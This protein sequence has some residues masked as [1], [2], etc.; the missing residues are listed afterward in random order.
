[1]S[2]TER[3]DSSIKGIAR[4]L[5]Q[6][7]QERSLSHRL[8]HHVEPNLR[9]ITAWTAYDIID[10][11]YHNIHGQ[12][13]LAHHKQEDK[14]I[15]IYGF[16]TPLS[17][18]WLEVYRDAYRKKNCSVTRDFRYGYFATREEAIRWL[19]DGV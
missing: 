13:L 17:K 18:T 14:Y 1:M 9:E 3:D 7:G 4:K 5:T 15:A 16:F 12:Y 11:V 10:G 6:P 2:L 19:G 8:R